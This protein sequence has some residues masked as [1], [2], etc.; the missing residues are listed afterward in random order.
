MLW[1]FSSWICVRSTWVWYNPPMPIDL[2]ALARLGART[3]IAELVAEIDALLEAF[4]DLGQEQARPV[5]TA[6]N[7]AKREEARPSDRQRKR[8]S[9]DGR[10]TS[11]TST[12][13]DVCR[14]QE[15]RRRADEGILAEA[16]RDRGGS[17]PGACA[18]RCERAGA[19]ETNRKAHDVR[20][21]AGPDQR[22]TEE[23]MAGGEAR[24]KALTRNL[25]RLEFG[26][27]R[28]RS[29]S[30]SSRHSRALMPKA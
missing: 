21:G 10:G 25:R 22:G 20:R 29:I 30:G 19:G 11:K 2:K 1:Q 13:A 6:S 23:T 28:S 14:R 24:Q 18:S 27:A 17:R 5:A 4:P 3:R 26:R 12:Q 16:E 7:E 9:P 8:V 15:G